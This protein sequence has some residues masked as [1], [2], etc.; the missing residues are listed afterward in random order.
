MM[1]QG[2]PSTWKDDEMMKVMMRRK[3]VKILQLGVTEVTVTSL[4]PRPRLVSEGNP[5]YGGKSSKAW[6]GF[7]VCRSL[8]M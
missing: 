6:R 8:I 3:P 4:A 7:I 5:D 2:L 1:P